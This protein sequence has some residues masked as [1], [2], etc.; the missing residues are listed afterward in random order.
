MGRSLR[1]AACVAI[2]AG[3]TSAWGVIAALGDE[4]R[5]PEPASQ[6]V[7]SRMDKFVADREVAGIATLVTTPDEV[8]HL[9]ATGWADLADQTPLLDDALFCIASMTKPITATAVMMLR[10]EGKLSVDDPVAKHLPEFADLRKPDGERADL[11]IRHLL[12][13][14]SGMH[15]VPRE[16]HAGITTLAELMPHCRR[17]PVRFEPGARW[18]YCQSAINTA[19]RIVEVASGQSLPDF[20]RERLFEPLGM[21]DTTFYLQQDQLP[22]LAKV[23]HKPDGLTLT[24]T[25]LRLLRGKSPTSRDRYPLASG[26]LFSTAPDYAR[27]CRMILNKGELDGVRYLTASAVDEMTSLQTGDTKAGFIPGSGWGLGWCVVREPLGVA[28]P[29][30]PGSFGHGGA[31]GT[32]AWI[33]P[34]TERAYVL[35]VQ[36]SDWPNSD[37]SIVREAFLRRATRIVGRAEP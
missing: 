7:Q 14:T 32:Q 12:T 27:F 25:S 3:S 33:D 6:S 13:H 11:T 4:L 29:L 18:A 28:A 19:G 10:D 16:I 9:H 1:A 17:R 37:K 2:A 34:T 23:Y 20:L 5:R 36:R 35:M 30:S 21:A 31:Y 8:I 22:R 15:D 24:E 26:G